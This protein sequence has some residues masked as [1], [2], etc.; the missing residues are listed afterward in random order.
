MR[1][2]G[3]SAAITVIV[4]LPLLLAVLSGVV[5]IGAL[6]V[7]ASRVATAAD[8]ATLAATDD[9]DEGELVRSGGLQLAPDAISVARRFFALNLSQI[10]MHLDITPEQAAG[11]A[12]VAVFPTVPAVDQLT[13]WRYDRPT[14]RIAAVVPM[15]TPA[16]GMLLLPRTTLVNVRAAS[17]AR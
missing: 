3:G 1:R 6:R 10:A 14:V 12:D 4:L 17:S 8:L 16:F 7:L 11:N 2:E 13:G 15:R 5:Q 9:Q